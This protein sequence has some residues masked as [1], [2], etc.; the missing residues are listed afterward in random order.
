V[1]AAARPFDEALWGLI[2]GGREAILATTRR[3]GT[4]HL[5]NMLYV[6][7]APTRTVRIS[8]K[9]DTVK[10]GHLRRSPRASIHVS[11]DNFWA[12]AVAEGP[13]TLS[14]VAQTPG[15]AASEELRAIHTVFY[16]AQPDDEIYPALIAQQRI[17]VRLQIERVY[18][19]IVTG[20]RR[21]IADAS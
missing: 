19:L 17:V 1:T 7:D 12:Y 11:G 2:S 15:D 5:S 18:G 8:T 10:I 9:A 4:P 6:L 21:P 3:D 16:G 14:D 20:A 13:V